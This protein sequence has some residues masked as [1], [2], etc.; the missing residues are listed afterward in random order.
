VLSLQAWN[1]AWPKATTAWK[2]SSSRSLLITKLGMNQCLDKM[3]ASF[4]K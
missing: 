3:A 1:T 2:L 4:K